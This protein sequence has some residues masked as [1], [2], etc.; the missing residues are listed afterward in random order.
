MAQLNIQATDVAAEPLAVKAYQLPT[1]ILR[2]LRT[3][4]TEDYEKWIPSLSNLVW[5][6]PD[7][8]RTTGEATCGIEI[9]KL[10][11]ERSEVTQLPKILLRRDS[12]ADAT[13]GIRRGANKIGGIVAGGEGGY[14]KVRVGAIVLFCVSRSDDESERIGFEVF[15]LFGHFENELRQCLNLRKFRAA[16][17]GTVG[18]LRGLPDFFATPVT[19]QYAYQE[20]VQVSRGGGFP[21]REI[22]LCFD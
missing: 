5:V 21:L 10:S 16:E 18:K 7:G 8:P 17:I 9:A 14:E 22:A 20:I 15:E 13:V 1:I 19:L 2:L 11:E 4:F 6:D 12:V 3:Y